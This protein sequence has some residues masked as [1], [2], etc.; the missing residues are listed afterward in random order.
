[1]LS[2]KIEGE[3]VAKKNS[4]QVFIRGGRPIVTTSERYKK[5]LESAKIQLIPQINLIKIQLPIKE[6]VSVR[7]EFFHGDNR[8]RDSDNGLSSIL[9][10]LVD[11]GVLVDDKWQIVKYLTVKNENADK[12]FCLINI[13]KIN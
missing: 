1:M 10:L 4:K 11:V 5:W 12:S 9:D 2:F 13:D 6:R 3:T 7:I 8:R